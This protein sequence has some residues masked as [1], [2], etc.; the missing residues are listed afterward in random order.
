MSFKRLFEG[1]LDR[2]NFIIG[3]II[4]GIFKFIAAVP[5]YAIFF[6]QRSRTKDSNFGEV[7]LKTQLVHAFSIN[8]PEGILFAILSTVVVLW[9]L[10]IYVRRFHDIGK[11]GKLAFLILLEFIVV[12]VISHIS[13]TNIE[14]GN[15][16]VNSAMALL[17]I[18]SLFSLTA[19]IV[20]LYLL[21]KKTDPAPNKY[22]EVPSGKIEMERILLGK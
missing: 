9:S 11:S 16:N 5:T 7:E 6:I 19:G 21:L 4:F 2:K 17:S 20:I 3:W 15:V 18:S 13:L 12:R 8:T 10:A 1:R 22:G 14:A